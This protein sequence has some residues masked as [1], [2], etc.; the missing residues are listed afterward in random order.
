MRLNLKPNS[1]RVVKLLVLSL[2][3]LLVF[4]PLYTSLWKG[5]V[6]VRDGVSRSEAVSIAKQYIKR[7]GPL[8]TTYEGL[9]E[10]KSRWLAR[11][12]LGDFAAQYYKDLVTIN[13]TTGETSSRFGPSYKDPSLLWEEGYGLSKPLA[14]F[15]PPF[16]LFVY[17]GGKQTLGEKI[18]PKDVRAKMFWDW[19]VFN[20]V[21]WQSQII[22]DTFAPSRVISGENFTLNVVKSGGGYKAILNMDSNQYYKVLS[23]KDSLVFDRVFGLAN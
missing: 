5:K 8:S 19:A 22:P 12:Y 3:V 13:R 6:E 16:E 15:K 10:E 4:Y 18:D 20:R 1:L 9:I 11:G 23:K 17:E 2:P 21:G 14:F 7:H